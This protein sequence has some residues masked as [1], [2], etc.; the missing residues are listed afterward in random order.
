MEKKHYYFWRKVY[1]LAAN[2]AVFA[3]LLLLFQDLWF[4]TFNELLDRGYIERGNLLMFFLYGIV[5]L[6]VFYLWGGFKIGYQKAMNVLLSQSLAIICS[7][8]FLLLQI[9]LLV[10][11][12]HEV[13]NITRCIIILTL[14]DLVICFFITSFMAWLYKKIFKPWRMLLIEGDRENC[15]S[16]KLETR[17]DKYQICESISYKEKPELL[18][19]KMQEYD[20]VLLNE[21]P[22]DALNRILQYC[23]VHSIRTYFTPR[24][25]DI[26]VRGT[27]TINLFDSPLFLARNIGLSYGEVIAKRIFDIIVSVLGL[28]LFSPVFLVTAICVK[29]YDGGKVFYHQERC[30]IDGKIFRIHKFRSMITGAEKDGEVLPAV[31]HD[32]RITPVGRVIRRTHI[33]ELPQLVNVLKGD[34]SIVGPR[35]ER[36]EHVKKYCEEIP[37]FAYR[38]KVKGGMTGYAQVYGKYNTQAYDKLKMD[39]QY[40]VNYSF[41]LDLQIIMETVKIIIKMDDPE[42]FETRENSD[43]DTSYHR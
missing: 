43:E 22:E 33:D 17:E 2:A 19:A 15:I 31:D 42:G 27:D 7:N 6:L 29:A 28:I 9:I 30:T 13:A 25:T 36:I 41:L 20:A 12:M 26:I 16:S 14:K 11:K 35:P 34:M 8:L 40:I 3:T 39:L 24:V 38:M 37:E 21:L 5:I 18:H 1:T 4:D 32:S 10:A 23:F